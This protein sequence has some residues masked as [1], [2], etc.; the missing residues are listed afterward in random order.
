MIPHRNAR[1]DELLF[2]HHTQQIGT[3]RCESF[4]IARLAR[5]GIQS[6][7]RVYENDTTLDSAILF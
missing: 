4:Q 2:P 1:R 6:R 7:R 5:V 3:S